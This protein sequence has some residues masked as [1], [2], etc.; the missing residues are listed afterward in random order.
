MVTDGTDERARSVS[1]AVW[2]VRCGRAGRALLREHCAP[3]KCDNCCEAESPSVGKSNQNTTSCLPS[4]LSIAP[5]PVYTQH[6]QQLCEQV[7]AP[8]SVHIS[9]CNMHEVAH[10]VVYSTKGNVTDTRLCSGE[11]PD[12]KSPCASSS[13]TPRLTTPG[14]DAHQP[15]PAHA[16]TRD[17][18]STADR[19]PAQAQPTRHH[20][21]PALDLTT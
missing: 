20:L 19:P 8:R 14:T 2:V 5:C 7:S 6:T 3:L 10:I 1:G 11:L 13:T 18:H 9:D 4:R 12:N 17:R 15:G 21:N 16:R